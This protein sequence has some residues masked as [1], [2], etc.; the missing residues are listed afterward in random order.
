ML[1]FLCVSVISCNKRSEYKLTGIL[2]VWSIFAYSI[3][4]NVAGNSMFVFKT[5]FL[6]GQCGYLVFLIRDTH[7]VILWLPFHW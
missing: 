3:K 2:D 7:S 4:M 1:C 5:H 6:G